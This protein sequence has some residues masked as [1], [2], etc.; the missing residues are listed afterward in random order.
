M[1]R[2]CEVLVVGA[3]P[4]GL[5]MALQLARRGVRVRIID[6]N[7]G[8]SPESRAA[9]VQAR[10][11]ELFKPLGLARRAIGR[12]RPLARLRLVQRGR[13]RAELP[14]G[15]IGAGLSEFPFLLAIGQNETE[16]LLLS[17]LLEHGVAVERRCEA[18]RIEPLEDLVRVAVRRVRPG[19]ASTGSATG[20]DGGAAPRG[21]GT[22]TPGGTIEC[23]WLCG[24]DGASSV[25]RHA[26]GVSFGGATY[27]HRFYL[28]D[29]RVDGPIPD[30]GGTFCPG[31]RSLVGFIGM[32]GER[33]FRVIG[34]MPAGLGAAEPIPFETI[35]SL[36]RRASGLP[37]ELSDPRWTSV[38][39]LHHRGVDRLR[40]GRSGRVFLLG[41]AA[42]VHSPVGGQGMNTGIQDASN[43]AWKLAL[44]IAGRA[45]DALL[46]TYDDERMPVVR[47]L[48]RTTD[49]MFS[50]I[51]TERRVP[52]LIRAACLGRIVSCM[53][54]LRAVRE[55]AFRAVSQ[56]GIGY[57]RGA[58]AGWARA[59]GADPRSP[60]PGERLPFAEFAGGDGRPRSVFDLCDGEWFTAIVAGGDDADIDRARAEA[61]A[62]A[63]LLCWRPIAE[64]TANLRALAALG[65]ARRPGSGPDRPGP[66]L[67]IVRPDQH[68]FGSWPLS[69]SSKAFRSLQRS[70][71]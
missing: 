18:E 3:G 54:R 59:D 24:C 67:I 45:G 55:R 2:P 31:R 7:D 66:R 40:A 71:R 43:L 65:H 20:V 32:A 46:D 63:P 39:R 29:C 9:V 34:K 57:R 38:Y 64:S 28:A 35:A 52:A 69:E 13:L 70:L 53:T 19:A 12:G 47:T 21:E 22:A 8:P 11:L 60:A 48:L 27:E 10:T 61:G 1:E 68:V 17:A 51:T 14:I 6:R 33:R 36:A 4:T 25:V 41:D 37:I 23:R 56:I 50:F 26:V 62:I 16:A 30:D 58:L 44:V 49:R 5:T 15:R 42:H